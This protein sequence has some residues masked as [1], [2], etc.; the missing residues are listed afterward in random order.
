MRRLAEVLTA[1]KVAATEL[2]TALG[3]TSVFSH[4]F[5]GRPC[6]HV[7]RAAEHFGL[8]EFIETPRY[9]GLRQHVMSLSDCD[10][11]LLQEY[12]VVEEL[13]HAK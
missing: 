12:L 2:F 10:A 3:R 8:T 9:F 6:S 1:R 11:A 13:P 5:L 4:K 7:T